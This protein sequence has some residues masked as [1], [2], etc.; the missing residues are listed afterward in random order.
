M[1]NLTLG[2]KKEKIINKIDLEIKEGEF[3]GIIG[4]SGAGKST[5]LMSIAG[6]IKVFD[7]NFEVLD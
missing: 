2:Y 6:G 7:G 5:L 3:V 1:K 4:P